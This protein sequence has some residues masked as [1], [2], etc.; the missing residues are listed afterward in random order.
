MQPRIQAAAL[1]ILTAGA[2][3]VSAAAVSAA[4]VPAAG[5]SR[6]GVVTLADSAGPVP[7]IPISGPCPS[8][9]EGLERKPCPPAA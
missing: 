7:T 3:V 2:A 4:A 6:P 8:K 1:A 5:A 9:F